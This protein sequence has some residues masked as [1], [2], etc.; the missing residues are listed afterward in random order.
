MLAGS[1]GLLGVFI[2]FVLVQFRCLVVVV[3]PMLGSIC[4]MKLF[5]MKPGVTKQSVKHADDV[6][7]VF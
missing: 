3:Q 1:K 6:E 4:W 7:I 5:Q 2:S